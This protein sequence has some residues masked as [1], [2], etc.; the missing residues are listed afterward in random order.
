MEY[1]FESGTYC[2]NEEGYGMKFVATFGAFRPIVEGK[3]Q[4]SL[5]RRNDH[6]H[7]VSFHYTKPFYNHY[8]YFHQVADEKLHA[9]SNLIWRSQSTQRTGR[10]VLHL[11]AGID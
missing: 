5:T 8:A 9:L 2:L 1:S 7:N 4:H 10:G 6:H 3:T 11:S